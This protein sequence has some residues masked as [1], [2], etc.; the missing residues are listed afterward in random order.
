MDPKLSTLPLRID[1]I[2]FLGHAYLFEVYLFIIKKIIMNRNKIAHPGAEKKVDMRNPHH[3][4]VN[5][6]L[7]RP[8]IRS[9]NVAGV[10]RV[11]SGL[12]INWF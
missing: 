3:A 10:T 6:I 12:I 5:A 1:G 9:P 2:I 4:R 11:V 8:T 7:K